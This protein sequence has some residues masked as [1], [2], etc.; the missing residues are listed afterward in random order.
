MKRSRGSTGILIIIL[1]LVS[2]QLT[3]VSTSNLAER[4][5]EG[6]GV[7]MTIQQIIR[8]IQ[9]EGVRMSKEKLYLAAQTVFEE[10]LRHGVDYRLILAIM[11]VESNF[12]QY[13]ISPDGARGFMQIQ[14]ILAREI[15]KEAGIHYRGLED[16]YD[17]RKNIRLG[18][19]YISKLMDLFDDIP[20][21]LFAYNV[22]HNKAK[23][24]LAEDRT[25]HTSYTRRVIAEY[26][27]N[28]KKMNGLMFM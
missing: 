9:E 10:S 24:L 5:N 6:T 7:A 20:E 2:L 25:P 26:K 16:L 28:T 12:R 21:V 19:Y 1:V 27:K 13:G 8:H 4:D 3:V 11:K 22:G 18:T 14:P 17:V 15:S 23:I